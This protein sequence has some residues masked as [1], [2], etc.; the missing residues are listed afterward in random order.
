[1]AAEAE[2]AAAEEEE[3]TTAGGGGGGGSNNGGDGDKPPLK[4]LQF[5]N[6]EIWK[7]VEQCLTAVLDVLTYNARVFLLKE[8][9]EQ[10]CCQPG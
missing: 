4:S 9:L 1:M 7:M 10:D 3:Q 5:G 8:G 6:V 2:A